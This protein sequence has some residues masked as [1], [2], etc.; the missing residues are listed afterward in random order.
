MFYHS[1]DTITYDSGVKGNKMII[2]VGLFDSLS[3]PRVW[4]D[5]HPF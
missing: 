1:C 3:I 4:C 2:S 5:Q